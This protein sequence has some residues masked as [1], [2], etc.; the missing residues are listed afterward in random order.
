MPASSSNR[1]GTKS[2][3]AQCRSPTPML[4]L[5]SCSRVAVPGRAPVDGSMKAIVVQAIVVQSN[6]LFLIKMARLD[7]ACKSLLVD[8]ALG[9]LVQQSLPSTHGGDFRRCFKARALAGHPSRQQEL[10][11]LDS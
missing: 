10:H 11:Q 5:A 2:P 9:H 7:A 1:A 4:A 6:I 8:E 3:Y